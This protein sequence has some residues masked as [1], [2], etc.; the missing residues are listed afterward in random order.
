MLA[1]LIDFH[2]SCPQDRYLGNTYDEKVQWGIMADSEKT[3][4]LGQHL[5]I[6]VSGTSLSDADKRLLANLSPVGIVFFQKNFRYDAPYEEWVESFGN[7]LV[8]VR[9]YAERERMLMTLDHEG[10]RVHRTPPPLTRFPHAFLMG[11]QAR[12]VAKA[13][14]T[15]LKSIGINVSWSP[16]A[17]IF[18]HPENPIIGPRAF[19]TEPELAGERARDYLQGLKDVGIIG[20]AKHFP[21]HG[22]TDTDSHR[23]L[24]VLNLT[25][26]QLYQRELIPFQ[27][28]IAAQVPIMM[29]AHILFPKIDPQVPA[30]LSQFILRD[31]LRS[32]LGYQGVIVSDDVDMD[33][34][35]KMYA[36]RGT[37]A[38][39]FN[40]GCDLLMVSQNL[41]ASNPER[42]YAIAQDFAA[43]M[44]NGI[45]ATETVMA[46]RDRIDSLLANTPQ[47][48][49]HCLD[50][51]TLLHHAELALDVCF[52]KN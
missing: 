19:A 10:G 12:E 7:L 21:G 14:G 47:Y 28:L 2:H 51:N 20:C 4:Q 23:E 26:E 48:P 18:S 33:A 40:A 45:L 44:D 11:S 31:L 1:R 50:K 41:P 22:D 27:T 32:Q 34:V 24:P 37:V 3:K 5:L 38:H 30:T 49:V 9:E 43:S 17:D 42:I 25:I 6:G 46:A 13:T 29:T 39:T 52:A 15:E 8:Q 16:D 36:N 35:A